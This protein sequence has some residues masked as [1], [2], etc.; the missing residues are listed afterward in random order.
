MVVVVFGGG[1]RV[2]VWFVDVDG[3]LEGP[4]LAGRMT[5]F[6]R[7]SV[8]SEME[9]SEASSLSLTSSMRG[10]DIVVVRVYR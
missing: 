5:S 10:L 7:K 3:L 9:G 6:G 8:G 4:A 1:G 2:S